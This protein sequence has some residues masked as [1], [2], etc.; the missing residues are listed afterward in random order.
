MDKEIEPCP[1]CGSVDL[2]RDKWRKYIECKSCGCY[3]P[4]AIWPGTA[5]SAWNTRA[6]IAQEQEG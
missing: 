4:D 6:L 3:G 5:T 1:F 2:D